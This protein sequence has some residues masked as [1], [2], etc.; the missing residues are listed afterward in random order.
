VRGLIATQ[1]ACRP[2]LDDP[3]TNSADQKACRNFNRS[4]LDFIVNHAEP[5]IVILGGNWGSAVEVTAVVDQLLGSGKAVVLIMP[6]LNIGLDV[7]QRWIESQLRAGGAIRE[8]K[9][10]ADPTLMMR[11]LR[12]AIVQNLDKYRDNPRL[13][14]LDPQAAICEQGSC[15]LVRNGQANFR[16]TAHISNVNAIQYKG[17]FDT[18]LKSA[19][20]TRTE[21]GAILG[22][23]SSPGAR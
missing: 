7:P 19:L 2:F 14:M 20:Q 1:S 4:T 9:V 12:A 16:D 17:L 15:Y 11:E 5:S 18:A 22:W 3:A 6:L 10:E 21:A 8:W 23:A 13:V